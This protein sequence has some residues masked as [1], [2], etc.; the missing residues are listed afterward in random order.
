MTIYADDATRYRYVVGGIATRIMPIGEGKARLR[1]ALHAMAEGSDKGN[2][3]LGMW[4]DDGAVYLDLGDTW[5]GLGMAIA[6]A[7][8]RGELAIYDT[9]ESRTIRVNG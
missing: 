4:E 2:L 3:T 9:W 1:T 5:P 7:E 6:I 8:K